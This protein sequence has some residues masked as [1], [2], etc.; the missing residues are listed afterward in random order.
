MSRQT[1]LFPDHRYPEPLDADT[2]AARLAALPAPPRGVGTIEQ[3]VLRESDARRVLPPRV[4]L[5]RAEGA[6]GDRWS[7]GPAPKPDAQVTVM[8]ADVARLFAQDGD[9]ARFGDNLFVDLDLSEEALPA[10]TILAVGSAV[11]QVTP[12]PHTGCRK[13]EARAGEAAR[14]ATLD[15]RWRSLHLRGIHL[16]VLEDGDVAVGDRIAV[17]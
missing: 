12:L 9:I 4:R 17:R 6:V 13:F 3:L 8:R 7:L 2:I 14:A 5:T 1:P 11:C 16:R 10:G 15:A